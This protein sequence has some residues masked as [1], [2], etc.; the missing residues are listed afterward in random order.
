MPKIIVVSSCSD[1]P[2]SDYWNDADRYF[3]KYDESNRE[4]TKYAKKEEIDPECEL[5]DICEY[6]FQ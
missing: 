4:I 2:Y 1:C 6:Q 5:Q 3:C